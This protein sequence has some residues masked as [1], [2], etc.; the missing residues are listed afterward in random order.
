MC[1]TRPA[2]PKGVVSLQAAGLRPRDAQVRGF[3][4]DVCGRGVEFLKTVSSVRRGCLT[5]AEGGHARLPPLPPPAAQDYKY[6][7]T[8][9]V[10]ENKGGAWHTSSTGYADE[11]TDGE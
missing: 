10:S 4:D 1:R 9:F 7:V 5:L 2:A 8:C 3:V 11:E 6:V